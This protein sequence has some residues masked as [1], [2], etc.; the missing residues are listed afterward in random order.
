MSTR[1]ERTEVRRRAAEPGQ[2]ALE[3]LLRRG[4]PL[5][6]AAELEVELAEASSRADRAVH[7]LA[8]G[9]RARGATPDHGTARSRGA[10]D[11]RGP[12]PVRRAAVSRGAAPTRGR[13]P[14]RGTAHASGVIE[15]TPDEQ[16]PVAAFARHPAPWGVLHLAAGDRGLVAIE[17]AAETADFVDDLARR[18]GGPVVPDIPGTRPA[19]HET[20][21]AA[22]RQ[23][24]EYFA[25][26]RTRFDLPVDLPGVSAWD[27]LVLDGARRL[28]YGEVTS[29]GNLALAIGRPRAARAVGGALGRNPVPL[30]IPCHRIVAGDGTLGGYG[31][32]GHGARVRML[33]VKRTL[34]ALEGARLA[35]ARSGSTRRGG[36]TATR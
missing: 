15:E 18:L 21:A 1:Q 20:L 16:R 29:Y 25:G 17:L 13:V 27:R 4:D 30:V 14:A 12:A 33:D 9:A 22:G 2:A 26:A 24:D 28:A 31:G 19:W 23:L 36:P 8:G 34:L 35:D 7:A 6:A 3:R 5:P 11:A 32:G 10:A